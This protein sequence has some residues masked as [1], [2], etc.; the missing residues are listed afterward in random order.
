LPGLHRRAVPDAELVAIKDLEQQ[1]SSR[2]STRVQ[3]N[4]MPK[5]GKIVIEYYGNDD[6]QRILDRIGVSS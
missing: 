4:H 2:L 6:L 1:V 5:K 3:I